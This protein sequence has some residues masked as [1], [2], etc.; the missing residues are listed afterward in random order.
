MPETSFDREAQRVGDGALSQV[1]R[2]RFRPGD[3][4]LFDQLMEQ[5]TLMT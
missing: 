4:M 1:V 5:G 2:S 3:A